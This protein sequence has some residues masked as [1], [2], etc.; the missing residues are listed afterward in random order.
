[1]RNAAVLEMPTPATPAKKELRR[2]EHGEGR[3][4]KRGRTWWVQYYVD[5]EQ[6]RESSKSEL[7]TVALDILQERLVAARAGQLAPVK[8]PYTVMRDL[9]YKVFEQ[10]K[11]KSLL[12]RKDGVRYIGPVPALDRFFEK[13]SAQEITTAQCRKFI[14]ER[15]TAG[16]SNDGINGSLRLLRR[17]FSLL[18]KEKG[19]PVTKVPHFPFLPTNKPRKDFL[20]QEQYNAVHAK[21]PEELQ[22]L[23]ETSYYTGARRSELLKLRWSGVDF[24]NGWAEAGEG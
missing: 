16:V 19:Y 8:V 21:M 14:E 23:F 12:T 7:K 11:N 18:V 24:E 20:T 13:R 5:G 6:V 9:L 10:Q 2:R 17:M 4:Y 3:V 22:P 1:M 15:Q